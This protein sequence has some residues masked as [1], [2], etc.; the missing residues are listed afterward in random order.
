MKEVK[1][2][3]NNK[4]NTTISRKIVN[5]K[6][7][8]SELAEI[9]LSKLESEIK[10][11]LK[12]NHIHV[13]LPPLIGLLIV[14]I[15]IFIM[16]H[17]FV[18]SI[19]LNGNSKV[20]IPYNT[21]YIESGATSK[22][23]GK[24]LT[25]KIKI[26]GTVDT[27]K[28]GTYTIVYDLKDGIFH[29]K[30]E[31]RV[32]V[33]DKIAPIIELTGEEEVFVCPKQEYSEIGYK[34]YDEYDGEL[35]DKVKVNKSKDKVVYTVKDSSGNTASITRK[36]TE[37]DKEKPTITL[38]G[39]QTM[40]LTLTDDFTEPGYTANDNCSGDITSKVEVS[41]EVKAKQK[42]TYTLTYKVK[43]D[44]N[45]ETVVTRTV[46]VSEKTDPNSGVIKPGVIYLTFDDGPSSVTTGTILDILKEENVKATFFVTNNGPDNLIKRMYD[47]GHTVALHTASHKYATV[48]A[49]VDAYFNDLNIVSNRVKR[50]TGQTSKIVRFP[51]G[52]SNTVSRHYCKGIMT[53]LSNE[54]FNRG[55]RYYDWNVDSG[56]AYKSR[57][58]EAVYKNVTSNLSKNKA[59]VV[60]MH[61]IKTWTRDALRDIIRYGKDNGYTFEAID[62]NTH[63]VRQHINN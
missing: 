45:N 12:H 33:V 31:R 58:K 4:K 10:H 35:T 24:D 48:Y 11:D 57:T 18:P 17:V 14:L 15:I 22:F 41:G 21:E 26:K 42:G 30:K 20:E 61:D 9:N 56:D 27:S 32:V 50:I 5:N 49:S 63:M 54:L 1:S 39:T 7:T 6:K 62:M 53:T 34:A 3:K 23:F 2:T 29:I 51:G 40:H 28:I 43:D 44:A 13:K 59:N 47:E 19:D 52:S 38:K 46:I 25:S 60:L 55:Y 8:K 37:S 16:V 36:L